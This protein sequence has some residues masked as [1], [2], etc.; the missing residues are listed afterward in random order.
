M[1]NVDDSGDGEGE[2]ITT[3]VSILWKRGGFRVMGCHPSSSV[4]LGG[5]ITNQD[6]KKKHGYLR[7]KPDRRTT[8]L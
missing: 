6:Q 1:E 5:S 8:W 3:R 4:L 2:D 7:S